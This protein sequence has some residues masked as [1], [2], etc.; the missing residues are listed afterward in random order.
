MR[1]RR[2]LGK[3]KFE[4]CYGALVLLTQGAPRWIPLGNAKQVDKLISR[5]S[6]LAGGYGDDD[7]LA[8]NL[9]AL[10]EVLWAPLEPQLPESTRRFIVSPNSQL[11]F[12]SLATLLTP[13]SQFLSEKFEVQYV[14]NHCPYHERFL[15]SCASKRQCS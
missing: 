6:R 4:D 14:S 10:Y 8:A 11:N 2:Y 13:E 3:A 1:H 15:R 5:Y 12:V 7:E 9:K